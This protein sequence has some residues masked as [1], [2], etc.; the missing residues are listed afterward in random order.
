MSVWN[1]ISEKF[2][3]PVE[4]LWL[5]PDILA[6]SLVTW[7]ESP[8]EDWEK[9]S[10]GLTTTWLRWYMWLLMTARPGGSGVIS[11]DFQK[12]QSGRSS[13][14]S[15]MHI[16]HLVANL[17]DSDPIAKFILHGRL[18]T[19]DF[20]RE[21]YQQEFVNRR[22]GTAH[23]PENQVP[24]EVRKQ[25]L[26]DSRE[27]YA[28]RIVAW[29]CAIWKTLPCMV[30]H[31]QL[32]THAG[33]SRLRV[34]I[35]SIFPGVAFNEASFEV[36]PFDDVAHGDHSDLVALIFTGEGRDSFRRRA[37]IAREILKDG[38]EKNEAMLFHNV[39]YEQDIWANHSQAMSEKDVIRRDVRPVIF[40]DPETRRLS[41]A[42]GLRFDNPRTSGSFSTDENPPLRFEVEYPRGK[43]S[44]ARECESDGGRP[45]WDKLW[46][47]VFCAPMWKVRS[48]RPQFSDGSRPPRFIA[49]EDT[50]GL[51]FDGGLLFLV[52]DKRAPGLPMHLLRITNIEQVDR[53][54]ELFKALRR[55]RHEVLAPVMTCGYLQRDANQ[56][57]GYMTVEIGTFC[58]LVDHY[59]AVA[60]GRTELL[61][62]AIASLVDGMLDLADPSDKQLCRLHYPLTLDNIVWINAGGHENKEDVRVLPKL[63]TIHNVPQKE[64]EVLKELCQFI[65]DLDSKAQDREVPL[66]KPPIEA[67]MDDWAR[68]VMA[69][70]A[71]LQVMASHKQ[72]RGFKDL[73]RVS[74]VLRNHSALNAYKDIYPQE[75][76]PP[77]WFTEA[78]KDVKLHAIIG[79]WLKA[80][81]ADIC[82]RPNVSQAEIERLT[83]DD[84][85]ERCM[86]KVTNLLERDQLLSTQ[87]DPS[88]K[89]WL[90]VINDRINSP[91]F[92]MEQAEKLNYLR[93]QLNGY[94]QFLSARKLIRRAGNILRIVLLLLIIG[95]FT[96]ISW[97]VWFGVSRFY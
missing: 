6:H 69:A 9:H 10:E 22:N 96:E 97:L 56:L 95:I 62:R 57:D 81:L 12:H 65:V 18:D 23:Q 73:L 93:S 2:S 16:T 31:R 55:V 37:K 25:Q 76:G 20:F 58:R 27:H 54:P 40:R 70:R 82:S 89:V 86:R 1:E 17:R 78:R 44:D 79:E 46:Q 83:P 48:V 30:I 90:E 34:S 35:Q 50:P 88:L 68:V 28:G 21:V 15:L 36:A 52:D 29:I 61:V 4:E 49:K 94:I 38:I 26:K 63:S 3:I 51:A 60:N 47:Q 5:M 42:N 87:R 92:N 67:E 45:R 39:V 24:L 7:I 77:Q 11:S 19:G 80:S 32:G 13:M 84:F 14:G 41:M 43:D 33:R 71:I 91:K 85:I 72:T 75:S 53:I 66:A 59:P 74:A 64:S 8:E